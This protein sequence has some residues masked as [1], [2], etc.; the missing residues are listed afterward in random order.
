MWF[1]RNS[2]IFYKFL[3]HKNNAPPTGLLSGWE[4]IASTD[5]YP[6]WGYLV[7]VEILRKKPVRAFKSVA[8]IDVY[9]NTTPLG[10][11]HPYNIFFTRL[12]YIIPNK[13]NILVSC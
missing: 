2:F 13:N 7:Y 12:K 6:L 4:N 3:N 10:V 8:Y 11:A 5:I 9:M 1:S